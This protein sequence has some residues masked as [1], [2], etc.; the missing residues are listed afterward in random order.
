MRFIVLAAPARTCM[1]DQTADAGWR[2]ADLDRWRSGRRSPDDRLRDVGNSLDADRNT[3]SRRGHKAAS[4]GDSLPG[5]ASPKS[6]TAGRMGASSRHSG[7]S[8]SPA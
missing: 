1:V 2:T 6:T 3:R 7:G 4:S 8:P 5:R